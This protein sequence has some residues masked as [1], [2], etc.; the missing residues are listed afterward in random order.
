MYDTL[1]TKQRPMTEQQKRIQ[2][3]YSNPVLLEA[4]ADRNTPLPPTINLEQLLKDLSQ[5]Y[6]GMSDARYPIN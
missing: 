5:V 3:I 1:S 2:T 4:L 6:L